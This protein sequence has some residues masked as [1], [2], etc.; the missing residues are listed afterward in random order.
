MTQTPTPAPTHT[1]GSYVVDRFVRDLA[2]E[3]NQR[4]LLA[5]E[6]MDEK[7]LSRLTVAVAAA[8]GDPH[9]S[10]LPARLATPGQ[11]W[12]S[13]DIGDDPN[14]PGAVERVDTELE[15]RADA[16]SWAGGTTAYR[17]VLRGPWLTPDR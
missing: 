11:E 2:R 1:G 12:G 13:V 15:A 14:S 9:L 3:M 6:D 17:Y 5:A 8:L 7:S 16:A 10:A 4:G